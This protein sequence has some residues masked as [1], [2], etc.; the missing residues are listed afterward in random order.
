V[1]IFTHLRKKLNAQFIGLFVLVEYG[2]TLYKAGE[3]SIWRSCLVR[4]Q[5]L[6][7]LVIPRQST[8]VPEE[9]RAGHRRNI[10][11]RFALAFKCRNAKCLVY[12]LRDENNQQKRRFLS[13]K[14][15]DVNKRS[16]I[17]LRGRDQLPRKLLLLTHFNWR[18]TVCGSLTRFKN[19]RFCG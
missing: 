3:R 8:F 1:R 13:E 15:Q 4:Y 12:H 10:R 5:R 18:I 14:L 16:E 2:K 11:L 9:A 7:S 19:L 17:R 6:N